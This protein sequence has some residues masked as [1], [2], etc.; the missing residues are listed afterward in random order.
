MYDDLFKPKPTHIFFF[1]GH[2]DS[3][4]S[5]G[6][7]YTDHCV[8]PATFEE[9]YR[10]A[11]QKVQ[12]E[13]GAKV[14]VI[15]ATSSVFEIC[16]ANADKSR[17]AGKAHSLFGKPEELEKFNVIAKRIAAE[18]G[19]DYVDVYAPT[20]THPDKAGLFNPNDG[21]H[22]SNAGNRLIAL[23]LLK[24]LG[25]PGLFPVSTT[26][27]SRYNL[28]WPLTSRFP[29]F[30]EPGCFTNFV[31]H[32]MACGTLGLGGISTHFLKGPAD[33]SPQ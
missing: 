15:S 1:L 27:S 24:H 30:T 25:T 11:I 26:R 18:L 6:S 13:T 20:Q 22:L 2:N 12:K 19:A 7:G 16:K 23:E 21:V 8:D 5:S 31:A 32:Q 14:M 28:F 3:K 33:E 4:V 29:S 17:D 10:L 9:Q